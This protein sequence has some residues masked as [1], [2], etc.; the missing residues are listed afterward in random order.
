MG[1]LSWSDLGLSQKTLLWI[2]G[3]IKHLFIGKGEHV[4]VRKQLSRISSLLP[5]CELRR[6]NSGNQAW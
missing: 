2:R 4:G 5:L 1:S 6:Q 3:F